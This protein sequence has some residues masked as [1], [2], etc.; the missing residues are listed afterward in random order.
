MIGAMHT[1]ILGTV[2]TSIGYIVLFLVGISSV[3]YAL[4]KMRAGKPAAGSEVAL[5]PNR[6]PYYDD[7]TLET[8]RLTRAL[9][10]AF[11]ALA[12]ISLVLPL[13]WLREPARLANA[14]KGGEQSFV[15]NGAKL[16]GANSPTNPTGL[17]C[18]DCH[19]ATG[20]GGTASYT[21]TDS[22][23]RFLQQVNWQAP[24][25][26]TAALRFNREELRYIITYGRPF[27]PM[28][29]WGVPGGGSEGPQAIEDIISYIDS[30]TISSKKAHAQVVEGLAKE[31][32]A[33]KAAGH[34]YATDGQA[35]FNLG[36]YSGFAGR[37]VLLRTVPHPG[38]VL[39]PEEE[40]WRRRLRSEPHCRDLTVP[41]VDPGIHLD[42]R[43]RL[44]GVAAGEAV[45]GAR[46]GHRPDAGF[47]PDQAL[48]P[49]QRRRCV[50]TGCSHRRNR[51]RPVPG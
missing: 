9:V 3:A 51:G 47:L 36:Y 41:R 16:F 30:I 35:L 49:Q 10:M 48:Q 15:D 40:R 43:L 32:A 39:R 1:M 27:S 11:V 25:L 13:Y 44:P 45:R 21:I 17:G 8:T 6:K 46:D 24:A 38:M 42:G 2:Q 22:A 26:D 34:P 4:T 31:K 33:A 37:G 19:G 12:L 5:A 29:A 23:G 7:R 50:T 18:A 14:S 28:A 20:A